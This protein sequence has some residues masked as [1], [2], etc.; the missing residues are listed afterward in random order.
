[1]D[2]M[3]LEN[4]IKNIFIQCLNESDILEAVKNKL[5]YTGNVCAYEGNQIQH[6]HVCLNENVNAINTVLIEKIDKILNNQKMIEDLIKLGSNKETKREDEILAKLKKCQDQ[7]DNLAVENEG[8]KKENARLITENKNIEEKCR[9]EISKY[10]I[11]EE[12]LEVWNCIN[13][14][15]YENRVYIESL[16]GGSD[17]LAILS[18]GR[19][20]NRIEQ[21]WLYLRDMAVKDDA[22]KIEVSKLN[23]YFEFCLKVANSTRLENEKY[24]MSDIELGSEF[25]MDTCIR[26]ADSKQLGKIMEIMVR[27]VKLGKKIKYKAIVR[28]V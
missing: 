5:N 12:S 2:K 19:D 11:F 16:C 10:S 25:N 26:T 8:L 20:D 9:I 17:V 24:I 1:M 3:E 14:L 27:S 6:S 21:L 18:L 7:N 23:S 15:S 22:E 4:A 13:A 28:V